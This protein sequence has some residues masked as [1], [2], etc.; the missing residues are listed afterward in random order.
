[1]RQQL[2]NFTYGV[3]DYAAYPIGMLI[4]APFILRNLGVAQ[5]GIWTVAASV[6]NIGSVV[7]SG[8][9]DAG[10]Q[11]IA[12]RISSGRQH[13]VASVVRAAMGIHL[14]LGLLSAAAIWCVAPV[15]ADRL[16][17]HDSAL[18]STSIA[19]IRLAGA[20]TAIRAI[21]AVCISTQKAYQRYGPALRTSIAGRLLSLAAAAALASRGESVTTIMATAAALT[22]AALAVQAWGLQRLV[23]DPIAPA[24]ED[25]MSRD[26][27]RF[28][29]F[30]WVLASTNVA[31]SQADRLAGGASVGAA[32][33]VSYAL[34]AQLCQPV[35]GLTAAGLHFLFPYLA[36]RQAVHDRPA[37]ARALLLTSAA[38]VI[39]VLI[40]AGSLL[41]AGPRLLRF[42][43]N[44]EVARA[45]TPLLP[46]V[47]AGSAMLALTVTGSYAMVA[48]GR[49]RTVAIVN[50]A[51]C[52]AMVLFSAAFLR[53]RGALA[54]AEGR[55]LFALIALCVYIPLFRGL[56]R[57]AGIQ[58]FA[59]GEA[60][61]EA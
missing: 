29:V 24:Y 57:T 14:I 49:V 59:S 47:L 60:V 50:L 36:S 13:E 41:G 31:F 3:L 56:R 52:F 44:E 21:E 26:L 54:L 45:G 11:R 6:V 17:M 43:A 2:S 37:I 15:L 40:G 20:L 1:M 53:G 33:I 39:L 28:G 32:A 27:L 38:N 55:I 5:Y 42:V 58:Y 35:Y 4:V 46:S 19:C 8:F 51:G 22:G 18:R 10:T 9:G 61:E 30:T 16:A 34:C 23:G 48:L 25:S 12:S 7:A